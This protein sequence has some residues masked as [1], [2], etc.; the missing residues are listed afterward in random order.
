MQYDHPMPRL[1]FTTHLK[2]RLSDRRISSTQVEQTFYS[3]DSKYS[4]KEQ[5][6]TVFEKRFG[7]QVVTLI[8]KF[9]PEHEWIAISAWIDPPY[10]GTK[11]AKKREM[12]IAYKKAGFWGKWWIT[13]RRIL[14]V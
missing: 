11:D 4:G 2:D 12:W 9:T 6:T 13:F 8:A 1:I 3:P 10:Q 14:G 5:G 7:T